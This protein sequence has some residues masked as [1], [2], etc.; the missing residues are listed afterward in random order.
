MC[1]LQVVVRRHSL[2]LKDLKSKDPG[3]HDTLGKETGGTELLNNIMLR[4]PT[5]PVPSQEIHYCFA[6]GNPCLK[7]PWI[8]RGSL[9]EPKCKEVKLS[10]KSE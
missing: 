3:H 4:G 6:P 2:L 10:Q 1:R 7:S 9:S 5:L 8:R